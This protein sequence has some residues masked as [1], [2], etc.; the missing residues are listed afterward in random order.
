[1][2]TSQ[3]LNITK[4]CSICKSRGWFTEYTPFESRVSDT[5][6]P[7]ETHRGHK[8]LGVGQVRLPVNRNPMSAGHSGHG[9]LVLRDVVHVPDMECNFIGGTND[10]FEKDHPNVQ[11][12]TDRTGMGFINDAQGRCIAWLTPLEEHE[13]LIRLVIG[14]HK[15]EP[16]VK[17]SSLNAPRNRRALRYEWFKPERKRWEERAKMSLEQILSDNHH[18]RFSQHAAQRTDFRGYT[19]NECR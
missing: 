4:A 15:V 12:T 18:Q 13:D 10:S 7:S 17:A 19:D 9:E 14:L 2:V 3:K 1:M 8:V 6:M 16:I 11:D 5:F